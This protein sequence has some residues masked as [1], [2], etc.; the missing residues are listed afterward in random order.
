MKKKFR[1]KQKTAP[2]KDRQL[3]HV[4][5][6]EQNKKLEAMR[7]DRLPFPY[8]NPKQMEKVISQPIGAT[9]NSASGKSLIRL[10]NQSEVSSV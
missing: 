6:S 9:W 5:I 10:V 4:I 7:I 1:L 8:Q 2:R 3:G